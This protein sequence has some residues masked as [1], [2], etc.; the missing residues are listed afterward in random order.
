LVRIGRTYKA[1]VEKIEGQHHHNFP[2]P[3]LAV[4]RLSGRRRIMNMHEM[5]QRA[6]R[7]TC[8]LASEA[9]ERQARLQAS[10]CVFLNRRAPGATYSL[11]P[12]HALYGHPAM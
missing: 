11:P 12:F 2:S 6:N 1:A 5:Q 4:K 8:E 9:W 10:G 3:V 7:S